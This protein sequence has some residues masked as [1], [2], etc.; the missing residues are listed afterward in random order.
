MYVFAQ[1]A[2][3]LSAQRGY[4]YAAIGDIA[5]ASAPLLTKS[6]SVDSVF[7]LKYAIW[8]YNSGKAQLSQCLG[9]GN[10]LL[11][12]ALAQASEPLEAA[13][14]RALAT[15]LY[16][17]GRFR[18]ALIHADRGA[19]LDTHLEMPAYIGDNPV[20]CCQLLAATCL[21]HLGRPRAAAEHQSR[22]LTFTRMSIG[23]HARTVAMY[24]GAYLYDF[25]RQ[26]TDS[27]RISEAMIGLSSEYGFRWWLAAALIRRGW[28]IAMQGNHVRGLEDIHRGLDMWK[29]SGA[30]TGYPYWQLLLAEVHGREKEFGKALECVESGLAHMAQTSER[31]IE[32]ELWRTEGELLAHTSAS[33]DR[34]VT[35]SVAQSKQR[36][37][38]AISRSKCEPRLH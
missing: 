37:G 2:Y 3:L 30:A 27:E 24:L 26:Y 7:Q 38:T 31:W 10:D 35:R 23:P 12:L 13:A 21:W 22:A 17:L 16:R 14:H 15:S 25:S 8:R 32:P 29:A 18:D 36:S 28:A 4:A 11:D 5:L 33:S 1:A 20:V 34:I 19:S 6:R 9:S